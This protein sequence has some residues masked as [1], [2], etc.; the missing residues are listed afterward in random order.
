MTGTSAICTI[1]ERT[2]NAAFSRIA[3]GLANRFFAV[4]LTAP[5]EGYLDALMRR[6]LWLFL[7]SAAGLWGNSGIASAMMPRQARR[8]SRTRWISS[9]PIRVWGASCC[10]AESK[11]SKLSSSWSNFSAPRTAANHL[12]RAGTPAREFGCPAA[13]LAW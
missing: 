8:P 1:F 11:V 6:G 5:R 10:D 13:R 3:K 9:G 2:D 4:R 12:T 7:T